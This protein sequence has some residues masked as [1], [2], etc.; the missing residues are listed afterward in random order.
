MEIMVQ[1]GNYGPKWK[2]WSKIDILA[3]NK[4]F[5][6]KSIFWSKIEIFCEKIPTEHPNLLIFFLFFRLVSQSF[7]I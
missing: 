4:N 5:V 3:T 2:F 1:N 7:T 6:Q